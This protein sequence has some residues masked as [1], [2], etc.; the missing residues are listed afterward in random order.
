MGLK[1]TIFGFIRNLLIERPAKKQTLGQLTDNLQKDGNKIEQKI[2]EKADSEHNRNKLIHII[3]I[4]RWGQSRLKVALGEPFVLDEYDGYS[5]PANSS[6][7]ELRADFHRTRESTVALGRE[8]AKANISPSTTI[9]H[10]DFGEMS[11]HGWLR[12][13]NFHANQ[14]S[15]GIK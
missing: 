8:L 12:Y 2:A 5:P 10:N 13:L 1:A 6:W 7:N 9:R 3:G 11:T 4:E 14:E 15:K